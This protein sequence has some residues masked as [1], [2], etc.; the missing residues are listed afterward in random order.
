VCLCQHGSLAALS[1]SAWKNTLLDCFEGLTA[2][3]T[4][5]HN[6]QLP[7]V[8]PQ[9]QRDTGMC[10]TD[11]VSAGGGLSVCATISLLVSRATGVADY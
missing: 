6:S 11:L 3:K 2:S 9:A 7:I 8:V 1:S 5:V 4:E 10:C